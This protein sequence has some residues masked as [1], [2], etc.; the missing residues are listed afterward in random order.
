MLGEL[1]YEAMGRMTGMRVFDED[2]AMEN[3][4]QEHGRIFGKGV[5]LP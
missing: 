4:L 3:T 2:G 1:T 5:V